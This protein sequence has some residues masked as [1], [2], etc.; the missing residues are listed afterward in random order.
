M[1][2]AVDEPAAVG[3]P[4]AVDEPSAVG[5]PAAVGELRCWLVLGNKVQA[6]QPF[7]LFDQ[8]LKAVADCNVFFL[9]LRR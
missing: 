1:S 3:E 9:I 5:E 8:F 2:F 7:R 4:T 6:C